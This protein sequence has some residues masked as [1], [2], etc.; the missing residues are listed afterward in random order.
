MCKESKKRRLFPCLFLPDSK[1]MKMV[2]I[3]VYT[4]VNNKKGIVT[5]VVIFKKIVYRDASND[6]TKFEC[7]P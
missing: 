5:I 4:N 3:S 1:L 7:K 6:Q 2:L